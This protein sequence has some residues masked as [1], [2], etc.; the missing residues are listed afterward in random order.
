MLNNQICCCPRNW[1]THAEHCFVYI[2]PVLFDKRQCHNL[3]S[4]CLNTHFWVLQAAF[5]LLM[6]SADKYRLVIDDEDIQAVQSSTST[7]ETSTCDD[8]RT[9]KG[10]PMFAIRGLEISLGT[11][12]GPVN[13]VPL[14]FSKVELQ[15]VMAQPKSGQPN[16]I[17]GFIMYCLGNA[18]SFLFR[19]PNF[20][21]VFHMV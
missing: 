19:L 13:F 5:Q 11:S 12:K 15:K 10:T 18:P 16:N 17:I 9:Q 7:M 4:L 6:R 14:F 8:M 3:S 2:P 1:I 21:W 20:F